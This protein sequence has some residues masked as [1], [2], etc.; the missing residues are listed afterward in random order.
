M[1]TPDVGTSHPVGAAVALSPGG[2]TWALLAIAAPTVIAAHDPPS[3]TFYNQALAVLGWGLWLAWMGRAPGGLDTPATPRAQAGHWALTGMLAVLAAA[4]FGSGVFGT[5]PA[6][7]SLMGG[8]M[9]LAALLAFHS[10]W[11]QGRSVTRDGI[12]ELFFGALAVAG[13]L[14]LL[15]AA[16]QVFMPSWA[17]GTFIAS[18]N[19]AGRAVGNLRQPNHFSTLLVF[20]AAGLAWL[21]ARRRLRPGVAALGVALCVGG[22]RGAASR[23]KRAKTGCSRCTAR[24]SR[25]MNARRKTTILTPRPC[26]LP[27]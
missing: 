9:S 24:R 7:L 3:V 16:V 25:G 8:G 27:C 17:D 2:W 11:R 10:G 19:M 22:L 21:G 20:A 1:S 13:G 26:S 18:P 5:L 23:P 6:G 14:G 12:A 4:A 15:L